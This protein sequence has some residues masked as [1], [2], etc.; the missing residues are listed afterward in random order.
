MSSIKNDNRRNWYNIIFRN[1]DKIKENEL[2]W[3]RYYTY[4]N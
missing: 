3:M 2:G 4:I 1:S